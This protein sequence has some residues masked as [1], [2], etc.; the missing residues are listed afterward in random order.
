MG[1]RIL[2]S[3]TFSCAII[4]MFSVNIDFFFLRWRHFLLS[5]MN[6]SINVAALLNDMCRKNFYAQRLTAYV[7]RSS[8]I[9][10]R[11]WSPVIAVHFLAW[12]PE[13]FPEIASPFLRMHVACFEQILFETRHAKG[14]DHKKVLAIVFGVYTMYTNDW[15][16][17]YKSEG[18][19][20]YLIH[21]T[22]YQ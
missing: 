11:L 6:L 21:S 19:Q 3:E 12:N 18:N 20:P 2:F 14:H 10:Q 5:T 16:F 9:S 1:F 4:I 8:D 13:L 22:C 17:V 7:C 15:L